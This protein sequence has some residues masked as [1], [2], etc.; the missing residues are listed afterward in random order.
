MMCIMNSITSWSQICDCHRSICKE[1]VV[2]SLHGCVDSLL[3][4]FSKSTKLTSSYS[5]TVM[6]HLQM[7]YLDSTITVQKLFKWNQEFAFDDKSVLVWVMAWHRTCYKSLLEP[8]RAWFT[9]ALPG[10]SALKLIK[11]SNYAISVIESI[12]DYYNYIH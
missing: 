6:S 11:W 1:S 4:K 10:L 12:E 9:D 5:D 7:Q 3:R 2:T 8:I